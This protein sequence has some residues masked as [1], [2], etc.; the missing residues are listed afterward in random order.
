MGRALVRGRGR[1][2]AAPAFALKKSTGSVWAAERLY[3]RATG[4]RIRVNR[5][6]KLADG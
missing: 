4:L 1:L 5:G 6:Q 2:A 3:F